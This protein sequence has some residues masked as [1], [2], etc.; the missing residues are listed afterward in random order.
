MCKKYQS[1]QI[2]DEEI[3]QCLYSITDNHAYLRT[4]RDAV[5]KVIVYLKHYFSAEDDEDEKFSL[6]IQAGRGGARLS[7]NHARQYH[8]VLQS[9]MLWREISHE[10]FK[11]WYLAEEDLLGESN[12]YRLMDTGQVSLTSSRHR[13]I[14]IELTT[15]LGSA[16]SAMLKKILLIIA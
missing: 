5:D 6:A 12:Y 9:L 7:H 4:S 8:Y 10:M 2:T 1:P 11:L 15:V 13:N 14:L 16:R 3:K